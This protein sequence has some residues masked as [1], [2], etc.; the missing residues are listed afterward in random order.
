M[1]TSFV[2]MAM[3]ILAAVGA[4]AGAM[5]V[6]AGV[7]EPKVL[8]DAPLC[9]ASA[10][11]RLPC[12][13]GECLIVGDNEVRDRLYLFPVTDNEDLEAKDGKELLLGDVEISDIES[14]ARL[15]SNRI[16]VLGSHS[17]NTRCEPKKKRRRF[18]I[19]TLSKGS[20]QSVGETIKSKKITCERLL[21]EATDD[22]DILKA[23]CER[24]DDAEKKADSI[25]EML[26]IQ[27]EDETKDACGKAAPFNIEGAAT[28]PA[29]DGPEVWVGLRGPLVD[30]EEDGKARQFAVM[31]RMKNQEELRFDAAALVDLDGFSIR[32]LTVS[33]GWVWGIGGPSVDSTAAFTIWRFPIST[34]KPDAKI[35]PE[36]I[37]K[38]PTS[39]EGLAVSGSTAFVVIDG[40]QGNSSCDA[41]ARYLTIQ[42]LNH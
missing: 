30:V 5:E 35:Q 17:R 23:V 4:L 22:S 27:G 11:L 18:L 40:D 14:L 12:G 24:I 8:G 32:A 2:F 1:I 39:S 20:I 26:T 15:G 25:F 33:D 31:L 38:L 3:L 10:A 9:E 7:K 13:E 19:V 34:L 37:R 16:L 41:P 28:I 21:G 6:R 42:G 29:A 36:M